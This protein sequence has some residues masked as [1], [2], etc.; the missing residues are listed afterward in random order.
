[1]MSLFLAALVAGVFGIELAVAM[2]FAALVEVVI[3]LVLLVEFVFVVFVVVAW[4]FRKKSLKFWMSRYH[5]LLV[6]TPIYL[7]S[8][9]PLF[10]LSM[11]LNYLLSQGATELTN[12]ESEFTIY[13]SNS[14]INMEISIK[15]I[16]REKNWN[17]NTSHSK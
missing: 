10:I 6:I 2:V 15:V 12:N 11:L 8:A 3:E 4:N 5:G 9:Q 13:I 17:H 16:V 1:M 7:G 14:V